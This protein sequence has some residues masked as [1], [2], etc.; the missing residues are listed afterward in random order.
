MLSLTKITNE[1]R[2]DAFRLFGGVISLMNVITGLVFL[3]N[4]CGAATWSLK[5]LDGH[6]FDGINKVTHALQVCRVL[7]VITSVFIVSLSTFMIVIEMEMDIF[8]HQIQTKM[9]SS[10][11]FK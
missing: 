4:G 2:R 10:A 5:A 8:P 6:E 7:C 3:A 11:Y 9:L 1:Y